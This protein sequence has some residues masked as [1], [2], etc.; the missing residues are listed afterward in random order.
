MY[1]YSPA[2]A[3]MQSYRCLVVATTMI[4]THN[5]GN[6]S[7]RSVKGKSNGPRDGGMPAEVGFS[8]TDIINR[9]KSGRSTYNAFSC[10]SWA[11]D[12]ER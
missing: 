7:P 3:F 1:L 9:W 8:V 12:S 6:H 5:S 2:T 4:E 11:R 10:T